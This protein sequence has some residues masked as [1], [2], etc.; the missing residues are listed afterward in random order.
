MC[1]YEFWV[2]WS[3]TKCSTRLAF[4]CL[5]CNVHSF[6][7][8]KLFWNSVRTNTMT[9]K[10]V[11]SQQ[12]IHP[13]TNKT[14]KQSVCDSHSYP[15]KMMQELWF[16][17]VH[18]HPVEHVELLWLLKQQLQK[19]K[20]SLPNNSQTRTP[21]CVHIL[22]HIF[23]PS[24]LFKS[25]SSIGGECSLCLFLTCMQWNKCP[26]FTKRTEYGKSK[27]NA[28]KQIF[29]FQILVCRLDKFENCWK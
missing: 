29:C 1:K 7:K 24:F 10:N 5:I 9:F 27:Y 18:H 15:S 22:L 23:S 6:Q 20:A 3:K 19:R 16:F 21:F 4:L 25:V 8:K 26:Q 11:S 28:Q 14:R 13:M 12:V 17:V 2:S